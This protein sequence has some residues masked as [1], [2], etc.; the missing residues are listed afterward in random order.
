[1]QKRRCNVLCKGQ[2]ITGMAILD[3]KT[4]A[5]SRLL[6]S[7]GCGAVW[8]A[9]IADA[10]VDLI[11]SN[12]VLNLSPDKPAVLREAYRVLANGGEF[13]FSD[14][15]CDRRLP[16]AVRQHEVLLGECLGGALY[17]NDFKVRGSGGPA[18]ICMANLCS[19]FCKQH[20]SCP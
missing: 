14:V 5:S 16:A 13:Y 7:Q 1:M 19:L 20:G 11:I 17:V 18:A 9:G 12:C 8:Q 10:S 3:P 6:M 4:R 2:W 15:Y